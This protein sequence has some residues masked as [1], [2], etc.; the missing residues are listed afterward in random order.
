MKNTIE[1]GRQ[2][3]SGKIWIGFPEGEMERIQSFLQHRVLKAFCMSDD[4]AK[5]I[6]GAL[7]KELAND[8]EADV[9]DYMDDPQD[10]ELARLRAFAESFLN[11]EENGRAV[12]AYIRD[13]ARAAL[14]MDRV[15]APGKVKP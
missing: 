1:V 14:G 10:A 7:R 5:W 11:P 6:I 2:K 15:E 9:E 8:P 4:D 12:S 13:D 3:S